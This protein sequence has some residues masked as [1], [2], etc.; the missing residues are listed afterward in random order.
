MAIGAGII[1]SSFNRFVLNNP[2]LC[3]CGRGTDSDDESSESVSDTPDVSQTSS[4]H[5]SQAPTARKKKGLD[6]F[7]FSPTAG[8]GAIGATVDIPSFH[9]AS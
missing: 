5:P 6:N 4:S 8:A 3:S 2:L 7:G 9:I 1:V